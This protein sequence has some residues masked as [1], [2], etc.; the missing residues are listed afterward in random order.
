VVLM[1]ESTSSSSDAAGVWNIA[2]WARR[3][4]LVTAAR[5]QDGCGP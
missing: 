3:F 4:L 2:M 5:P 1:V